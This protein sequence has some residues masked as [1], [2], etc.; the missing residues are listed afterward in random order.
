LVGELDLTPPPPSPPPEPI[1]TTPPGG[2]SSSPDQTYEMP[3]P[4]YKKYGIQE[5]L[6]IIN[7]DGSAAG[8]PPISLAAGLTSDLFLW[9][10]FDTSWQTSATSGLWVQS[11]VANAAVITDSSGQQV[12]SGRASFSGASAVAVSVSGSTQFDVQGAGY[13]VF[14]GPTVGPLG[15]SADWSNY[16]ATAAAIM[17][18]A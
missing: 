9:G 6:T 16:T 7:N 17:C 11:L 4:L 10:T 3:E 1:D 12:G 2:Q 15:V 8:D 18:S 13:L 14:Y 5:D